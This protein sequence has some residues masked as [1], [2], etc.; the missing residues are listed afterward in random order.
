MLGANVRRRR[1]CSCCLPA[2]LV[3]VSVAAEPP[4]LWGRV[5]GQ[6]HTALECF[7]RE[8]GG[9]TG[10]RLTGEGGEINVVLTCHLSCCMSIFGNLLIHWHSSKAGSV[11]Q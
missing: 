6:V 3:L 8:N 1:N 10:H 7:H 2:G 5:C 11:I 9:C 4:G